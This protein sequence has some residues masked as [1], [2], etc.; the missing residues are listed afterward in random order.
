[1]PFPVSE[2]RIVLPLEQIDSF[3]NAIKE[4]KEDLEDR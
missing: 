3:I 2:E 4:L 1:M